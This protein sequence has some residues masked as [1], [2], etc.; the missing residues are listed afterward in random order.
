MRET[1]EHYGGGG[2]WRPSAQ[3]VRVLDALVAGKTNAEL[4]I[5]LGISPDGAKLVIERLAIAAGR[6]DR[7][8]LARWWSRERRRGAARWP[9]RGRLLRRVSAGIALLAVGVLA[10]LGAFGVGMEEDAGQPDAPA[11]AVAALPASLPTP[12]IPP[13]VF[14]ACPEVEPRL[15]PT[16]IGL[17]TAA[18]L[19]GQGMLRVP[20]S[21]FDSACSLIVANRE[22]RAFVRMPL[23]AT[24]RLAGRAYGMHLPFSHYTSFLSI[25]S[26]RLSIEITF[27][28][29]YAGPGIEVV[30]MAR[31]HD[32]QRHRAAVA[33]DGSL[34]VSPE[35]MPLASVLEHL[36]G[37]GL[38]VSG[39][40][41]LG[42]L[43]ERTGVY[44]LV[45]V[46]RCLERQQC[47]VFIYPSRLQAPISGFLACDDAGNSRIEAEGLVLRL[48]DARYDHLPPDAHREAAPCR[49]R[50]ISA[51][52][53]LEPNVYV[54]VSAFDSTGRQ[55]SVAIA[56]DGSLHVG[57]VRPALGCPCISNR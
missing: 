7:S 53:P 57:E 47:E 46:T 12:D 17:V 35:P 10:V 55:L 8:D 14:N 54:A 23:S 5:M 25:R 49:S 44:G 45:Y 34:W 39:T 32:G 42:R 41:K 4:G 22:D 48:R 27:S 16:G 56:E 38:D 26:T 24:S 3:Q 2:A 21:G 37:E 31:A 36:T 9:A 19:E 40:V 28:T 30:F 52:E 11:A 29:A 20:D 13:S 15:G 50:A 6:Q 43:H 33:S 18:V 1:G 51:G